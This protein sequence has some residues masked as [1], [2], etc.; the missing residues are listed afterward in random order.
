ME[1]F[2]NIFKDRRLD[3]PMMKQ[4]ESIWKILDD[5]AE[6]DQKVC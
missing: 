1:E 6:N 2:K 5:M 3:D 4:A